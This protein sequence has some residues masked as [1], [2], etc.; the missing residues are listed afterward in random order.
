[1]A[2]AWAFHMGL[3]LVGGLTL[4]C[5][6]LLCDHDHFSGKLEFVNAIVHSRFYRWG[7]WVLAIA[8]TSFAMVHIDQAIGT[9]AHEPAPIEHHDHR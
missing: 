7:L 2:E 5:L 8:L 4:R 3:E 9:H 1:M 6:F